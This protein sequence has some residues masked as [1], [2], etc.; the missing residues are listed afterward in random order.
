[1]RKF[2]IFKQISLT[3]L[4]LTG[5][6]LTACTSGISGTSPNYSSEAKVNP[7]KG[8]ILWGGNE[9]GADLCSLEYIPVK[10]SDILVA[11]DSCN[12]D[13]LEEKLNGAKNKRHQSVVR[14][15]IDEPGEGLYLPDFIKSNV[16][17]YPY[18]QGN[19]GQS[20]DY[21]DEN[22]L[23]QIKF[24]IQD[25][26]RNYDG[27]PRIA[28]IQTGIIG[29]WGEQHIYYCELSSNGQS[30]SDE[31][32]KT[33]FKTYCDSFSKTKLS[34]RN[35]LNENASLFP[36]L[37]FYNDMFYEDEN[38]ADFMNGLTENSM[39]ERWK[40]TMITGEFAPPLQLDFFKKCQTNSRAFESYCNR[41]KDQHVSSLLCS[42]VLQSG[43]DGK[44]IL[45]ASAALGYD[46]CLTHKS[47]SLSNGTLSVKVKIK[48]DGVA[49]FYYD[50]PVKIALYDGT[51]I[52]KTYETDWKIST[53]EMD[54]EKTFT[55]SSSIQNPSANYKVLLG[56][57]NPMEG[58]YPISFSNAEQDKDLDGWLSL[59]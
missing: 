24:L 58:G 39:T 57:P 18:T 30:I 49:P 12:W 56:I 11:E 45:N 7:L 16:T 19:G 15:V 37:G 25:F 17:L 9:K 36:Q 10:F 13:V 32:W 14:I 2:N 27:D 48:N 44:M 38:D 43:F 46:F 55:F 20:P 23:S 53:V 41:A 3:V 5:G 26:A 54:E 33:F 35:P 59:N 50:W 40:T 47:L 4:I 22:F 51:S 29:H 1:M 8:F 21:N 31:T 52:V 6:I 28:C 42:K 34:V